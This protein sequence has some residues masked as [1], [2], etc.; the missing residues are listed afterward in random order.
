MQGFFF[1]TAKLLQR[2]QIKFVSKSQNS[3]FM[4]KMIISTTEVAM[5]YNEMKSQCL[6]VTL[7]PLRKSQERLY[8][9]KSLKYLLQRSTA[10]IEVAQNSSSPP[11]N[12]PKEFMLLPKGTKP[13]ST[14]VN[15]TKTDEDICYL[16][17]GASPPQS[18][19]GSYF[20][21]LD[22]STIKQAQRVSRC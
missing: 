4:V 10:A 3:H 21:T 19:C 5:Y 2:H 1:L 6:V 16:I 22:C 8:K 9:T 20:T 12:Q 11:L 13:L 15:G 18:P 7:T 17:R 14:S